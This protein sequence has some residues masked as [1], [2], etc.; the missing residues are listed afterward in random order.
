MDG[1]KPSQYRALTEKAQP[2]QNPLQQAITRNKW[3]F[4]RSDDQ[5]NYFIA[6]DRSIKKEK[7]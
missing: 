3:V 6:P 7:R 2:V 4:L 1:M 5:F